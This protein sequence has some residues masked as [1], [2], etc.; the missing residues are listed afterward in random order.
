MIGS[1][2]TLAAGASEY[3][4][5]GILV[6]IAIVFALVNLIAS[7]VLGPSRTGPTKEQTYETGMIPFHT[8]RRRFNIRFYILAMTFLVF[9]V[10]IV[11][12]YPWSTVF[13]NLT[14]G[15]PLALQ[16]LAR[17]LFF[18]GTSVIAYI[19]AWRKGVFRYD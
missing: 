9:D 13:P 3:A 5:L 12:L 17:M 18:I 4:A 8:A 7:A 16:F 2:F 10:E 19:Y 14:H 11:F 6:L 1:N 15:S